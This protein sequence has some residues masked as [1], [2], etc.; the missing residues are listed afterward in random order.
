VRIA[1]SRS[2]PGGAALPLAAAVL[3]ASGLALAAA[4]QDLRRIAV[5]LVLSPLLEET[6]FR[7]G[8]QEVLRHR[9]PARPWMAIGVT[10]VAFGVAHAVA[11]ADT[12]AFG[13]VL[14]ALVIGAMYQRTGRLRDCIALHAAMNAAWL[15]YA[16]TAS[17]YPG[18][19]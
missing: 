19:R 13:V 14:P 10:A 15:G 17:A 12:A 4:G 6:V 9:W 18:F 7:A 8:V 1:L 3:L 5:L 11:R 16:V 2:A